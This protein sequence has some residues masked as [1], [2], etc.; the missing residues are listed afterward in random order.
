[1]LFC[2]VMYDAKQS[3]LFVIEQHMTTTMGDNF[4]FE[5]YLFNEIFM[6]STSWIGNSFF[7]IKG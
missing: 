5:P 3:T 1:M 4:Q 6:P 7:F 2:L